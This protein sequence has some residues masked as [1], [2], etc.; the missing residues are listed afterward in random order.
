MEIGRRLKLEQSSK[1]KGRFQP[2]FFRTLPIRPILTDFES[3]YVFEKVSVYFIGK[4]VSL[5]EESLQRCAHMIVSAVYYHQYCW[6]SRLMVWRLRRA[7]TRSRAVCLAGADCCELWHNVRPRT[8]DT[9]ALNQTGLL[10]RL[11]HWYGCLFCWCLSS[12]QAFPGADFE[13]LH[14]DVS[15]G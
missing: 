5:Q 7:I 8:I 9:S 12:H 10:S 11:R 15:Q 2:Y 4:I 13:S 1:R 3:K 6:L 14:S